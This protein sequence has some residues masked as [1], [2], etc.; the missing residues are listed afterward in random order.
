MMLGTPS[1]VVLDEA[2]ASLDTATEQAVQR[3][4][5]AALAGRTS[6]V[7]AHRLSTIRRADQ[8]LVLDHGRIVERGT[9]AELL[10]RR[11]RYFE[12]YTAQFAA[13]A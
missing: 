2:T 6:I 11:G 9:H 8:I 12:L 13:S 3:A 10:D 5:E 1:V 4:L 7:I